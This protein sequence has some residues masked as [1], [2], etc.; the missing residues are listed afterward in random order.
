MDKDFQGNAAFNKE[1]CSGTLRHPLR[2]RTV[3]STHWTAGMQKNPYPLDAMKK[4]K[5]DGAKDSDVRT[6]RA[7][8]EEV[9]ENEKWNL[10]H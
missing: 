10:K 6:W 9:K 7:C 8:T 5:K 1:N 4:L 3:K 2:C